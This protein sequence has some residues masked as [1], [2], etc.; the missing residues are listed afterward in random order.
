MNIAGLLPYKFRD[1]IMLLS[2]MAQ[3][4]NAFIIS[5]TE[6]HLTDEI[7]EAEIKIPN[8][9]AYRTDRPKQKKKG[10]VITY[11]DRHFAAGAK[12]LLSESNLFTEVQA[13]YIKDIE[14]LYINIYRPP[15][16]P[17]NKFTDQ[18]RKIREVINSLPPPMPT[19][20]FTGDLNFPLIDWELESVYG[21]AGDMRTQAEAV[22]HFAEEFCLNQHINTPTRG[23]NILDIVLTNN[24]ALLHNITVNRTNLSDHSIITLTTNLS[25]NMQTRSTSETHQALNFSHLNFLS[26]S[27]CWEGMKRD[28]SEIKWNSLMKDLDTE[29]QY[30]VLVTK[31]LETSKKHVPLRRPS[32]KTLSNKSNIP[33]DRKILMRKRTKLKKKLRNTSNTEVVT[34]TENKII[35]IEEKLKMS[36]ELENDRKEMQAVSCIKTN[37]KYF[38]KYA[39]NKSVVRANIG[40]LTDSDNRTISEPQ[41]IVEEL[42]LQYKSIFSSPVENKIINSPKEF[43]SQ[44]TNSVSKL[45][46]I[47][48]SRDNIENAIKEVTTNS[49]AGPDLFPA[50]L[51]K[52]CASELSV[53][54]LIF[55][56]NSLDTGTIPKQLKS[57]NI[58]PIYKGGSRAE[59]KS[60]R[61]V[62]LTS[63]IIKVLE[64][65]IVKNMATYLE[66]NNKMNQDQHGFRSGRSCLSQLLSHY[67]TILEKLEYNKNVD[68]VYL[69]F[70]KAFDKVDHGI[71]LHKTQQMGITGKLGMWLHSFLT[72]R[73]QRVVASGAVSQPSLVASGV[74]Q[75]SVLGP[76][77]FLIHITDINRQVIHSTVASFADDTR[78]LKEVSSELEA[79]QLQADLASL[80]S[81]ADHNNMSFNNNKFE[82]IHYSASRTDDSVYIYTAPDGSHIDTKQCIKDLGITLSSDGTF[83]QHIQH[84]VKKA[85]SQ[86]GWILR[87]FRT[88]KR[89]PMLT[90]YKSLVIPLVEYC[91][92]LWSPWRVGEK[93]S[94]ETIQRSFTSKISD[95]QHLDYWARLQEL[96]LYSL[97]R[98]RERYAILYIYKILIGKSINNMNIQFSI[99]Q[100]RGRLCHI[101]RIHSTASTRVKTLKE[102]AF[103]IRGPQ[104]FNALP[105]HLRD[106]PEQSLESF[107][108]QLDKFLRTIPDQPKLPHYQLCAASNSII[109]QLAQRRADGLY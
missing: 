109:D 71:L 54:L 13:L 73:E 40:P 90:L 69:D 16:C 26:E 35:S 10:G 81:W 107:K 75:G 61:P 74:P 39:A 63:H 11:V 17:T 96:D 98:R 29:S 76:I 67:E 37:P 55:Y 32:K 60:Y 22:L 101:E 47:Y 27:V 57:A 14:C 79:K 80:Y 1:K 102:N 5:L 91:C 19:I 53:P 94:L 68:V 21:G 85:R 23:T 52:S 89:S 18:L 82:H 8:F 93:Q 12:I 77:L 25:T 103:A 7:R 97:E 100:R 34:Q 41:E 45:T 30:D 62:S 49:A 2:E 64:R 70:A 28:L 42:L 4:E 46:D 9:V 106:S 108:N 92:Q 36:V 88:R 99:H 86:V 31:C 65:I 24:D 72:G 3:T 48:L 50:V 59:A 105:R 20:I 58:T 51:L 15:A 43:F 87:T 44:D 38:Y 83:T 78:V 33:R 66:Q 6:T 56:R 104:L 84:V 95:I